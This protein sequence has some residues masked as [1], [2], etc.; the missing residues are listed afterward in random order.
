MS[1]HQEILGGNKIF[2]ASPRLTI[3]LVLYFHKRVKFT[4]LQRL[5]QLT[6]GNLDHHVRKLKKFGY[7]KTRKALSWRPLTV[8]EITEDGAKSF[9][10][11]A[12]K[13]RKLLEA[14]K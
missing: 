1:E 10:E 3:M 4:D 7:V 12:V 14:V 8:I 5:L 11:Y 6:P 13:L 9:H 2:S